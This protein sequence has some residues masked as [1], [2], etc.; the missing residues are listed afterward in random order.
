MDVV[1]WMLTRNSGNKEKNVS[2][3]STTNEAPN[4]EEE[5]GRKQKTSHG[6]SKAKRQKK[7]PVQHTTNHKLEERKQD[8]MDQKSPRQTTAKQKTNNGHW[9]K[10]KQTE[11]NR[12]CHHPDKPYKLARIVVKGLYRTPLEGCSTVSYDRSYQICV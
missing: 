8:M 6:T 4:T 11:M 12:A 9:D 3:G 7:T 10:S 1:E 5:N 2:L